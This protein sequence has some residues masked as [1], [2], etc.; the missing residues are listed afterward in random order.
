[1]KKIISFL[2]ILITIAFASCTKSDITELSKVKK[3]NHIN[4]LEIAGINHNNA[5]IA[6]MDDLDLS[7]STHEEIYYSIRSYF[8]N[9]TNNSNIA[10]EL[11]S[12]GFTQAENKLN[13]QNFS[14]ISEYLV[15]NPNIHSSYTIGILEDIEDALISASNHSEAE[16]LLINIESSVISK[17]NIEKDKILGGL[18]VAR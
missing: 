2:L 14:N 3:S 9:N 12:I 13:D 10:D 8:I 7:N 15:V 5:I 6:T 17:N 18:A 11:N 4:P 1:M 16:G